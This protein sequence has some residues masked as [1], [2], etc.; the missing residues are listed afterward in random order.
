MNKFAPPIFDH[1][2]IT[3][4]LKNWSKIGFFDKKLTFGSI[5]EKNDPK[6][7]ILDSI[8]EKNGPKMLVFYK[9]VQVYTGSRGL[10]VSFSLLKMIHI[11][12]S[13]ACDVL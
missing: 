1:F 5:F 7:T 12:C 10:E 2:S 4:L 6:V 13:V 9:K 11:T 8:F 3:M